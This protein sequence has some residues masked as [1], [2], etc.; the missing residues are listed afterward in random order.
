MN[1]SRNIALSI[2]LALIAFAAL[3]CSRGGGNS[4]PTEAF[5]TL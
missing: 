1:I 3:A 2:G 4:T 5:K